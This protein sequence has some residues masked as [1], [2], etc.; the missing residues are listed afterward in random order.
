MKKN[1]PLSIFFEKPALEQSVVNCCCSGS[2]AFF[3]LVFRQQFSLYFR[4]SLRNR[5]SSRKFSRYHQWFQTH[6]RGKFP[7]AWWVSGLFTQICYCSLDTELIDGK[8][9]AKNQFNGFFTTVEMNGFHSFSF[10]FQFSF[11]PRRCW[12]ERQDVRFRQSSLIPFSIR[13]VDMGSVPFLLET[14]HQKRP[15]SLREFSIILSNSES[16]RNAIFFIS[17]FCPINVNVHWHE[18]DPSL[19]CSGSHF[20]SVIIFW[21][22]SRNVNVVNPWT[23]FHSNSIGSPSI[24]SKSLRQFPC[25][26]WFVTDTFQT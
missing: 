9:C 7:C 1:C 18:D 14:S 11:F 26:D 6:I 22:S 19:N 10:A 24:R 13:F 15:M 4:T 8:N 5:I 3:L 23:F 16:I 25:F 21:I 17:S 12:H 2:S 20:D